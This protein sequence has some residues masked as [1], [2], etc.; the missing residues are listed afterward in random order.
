MANRS[1]ELE[2]VLIVFLTLSWITVTLRCYVRIYIVKSFAIDD[3]FILVTLFTFTIFCGLALAS[4][5]WGTG[6]HMAD[7]PIRNQWNA[8]KMWHICEFVLPICTTTLRLSA[9]Y[10]LLRI[11]IKRWHHYV[12]HTLNIANITIGA[13]LWFVNVF[14]CK[15]VDYWWTRVDNK[16]VGECNLKLAANTIY[17]Q[18]AITAFIDWSFGLLPILIIWNLQM[19]RRKKFLV[20][21][22]LSLAGVCVA[23]LKQKFIITDFFFPQC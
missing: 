22:V 19:N 9:G 3:Y 10:F 17:A 15:P 13:Y 4:V 1:L 2:V 11:T 7:L 16:H 8:M 23:R 5:Y 14:Q 21:V 12:I 6:Q 18:S 20:G